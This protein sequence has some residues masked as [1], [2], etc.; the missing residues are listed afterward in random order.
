M[1]QAINQPAAFTVTVKDDDAP[2]I[3]CPAAASF[4]TNTACTYIGAFGTATATDNCDQDVTITNDAPAAFPLGETVVVPTGNT[5]PE[6]RPAVC[7]TVC[8][9]QLSSD[10]TV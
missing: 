10:V 4:G 8:P 6:A 7:F 1:L 5:L 9:S 2:M 3:T